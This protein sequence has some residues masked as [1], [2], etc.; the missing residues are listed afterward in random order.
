M[1]RSALLIGLDKEGKVL[2]HHKTA[3]A[4]TNANLWVMIGGSVES[5]E[6]ADEAIRREVKEELDLVTA[7]LMINI[8]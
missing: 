3:D 5:G 7:L 6:S 2:L 1:K 4:P 8:C